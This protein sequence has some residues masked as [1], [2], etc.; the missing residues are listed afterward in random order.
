MRTSLFFLAVFIIIG[1]LSMTSAARNVTL[2]IENESFETSRY[3]SY[4]LLMCYGDKEEIFFLPFKT[5]TLTKTISIVPGDHVKVVFGQNNDYP[6]VV[7]GFGSYNAGSRDA[8]AIM[9]IK[10]ITSN[11]AEGCPFIAQSPMFYDTE[12]NKLH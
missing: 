6:F 7:G 10:L 11:R 2:V 8:I 5:K 1:S 4:H 12:G 3:P 9:H